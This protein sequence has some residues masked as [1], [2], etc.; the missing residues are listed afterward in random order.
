MWILKT[1]HLDLESR[2]IIYARPLRRKDGRKE[3]LTPST[4]STASTGTTIATQTSTPTTFSFSFQ[5]LIFSLSSLALVHAIMQCKIKLKKVHTSAI[6]NALL[7]SLGDLA[8]L[9]SGLINVS[10]FLSTD[11]YK[12][13]QQV[14]QPRRKKMHFPHLYVE[15]KSTPDRRRVASL[16][17][18]FLRPISVII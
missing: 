11:V 13:H 7:Q 6:N 5:Q 1:I 18:S 9:A 10:E 17:F 16:L 3:P 12:L 8:P 2:E 14:Q 4:S 15:E